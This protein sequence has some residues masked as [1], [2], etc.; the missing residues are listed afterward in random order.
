MKLLCITDFDSIE[1]YW[2]KGV[3]ENQY[4]CHSVEITFFN[5]NHIAWELIEKQ[6]KEERYHL[7][8]CLMQCEIKDK[9]LKESILL[10]AVNNYLAS[11]M[12]NELP[13]DAIW[14]QPF[15][16]NKTTSYF[17]VFLEIHKCISFTTL[18]Q[19]CEEELHAK[20]LSNLLITSPI[21]YKLAHLFASNRCNYY[22]LNYT[23]N[24]DQWNAVAAQ[25][26]DIVEKLD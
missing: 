17:N 4:R 2:E 20:N 23:S 3:S 13:D 16:V 18:S 21:N 12:K 6:L 11:E 5:L 10:N 9:N 19:D 25:F 26:H 24:V 15:I 1:K 8:I 7:C 14:T 22:L